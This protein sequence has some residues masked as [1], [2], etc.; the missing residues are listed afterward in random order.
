MYDVRFAPLCE[1]EQYNWNY[2]DILS[3]IREEV[4]YNLNR[5]YK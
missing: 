2:K 1:N 3:L 4:K 5:H